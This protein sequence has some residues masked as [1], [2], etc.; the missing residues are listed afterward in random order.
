M[1]QR[2]DIALDVA[3]ALDYLHH[4]GQAPVVHCDLKPSNVLLDGDMVARVADFG[5]ARFI[6]N[7]MVSES[8][9]GS[10]TWSVGIKGTIGYIP[11]GCSYCL[12][13]SSY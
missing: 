8:A 3:A 11:P 1:T 13:C 4:H 5:L 6:R 10:S 7:K 12:V 2:V 9:G